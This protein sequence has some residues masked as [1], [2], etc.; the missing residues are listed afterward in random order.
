[1]TQYWGWVVMAGDGLHFVNPKEGDR[2]SAS[3]L[4]AIA[5]IHLAH[6]LAGIIY[7]IVTLVR[8]YKSQVHK[9][10]TLQIS[11]CN[12]YWHFIGLLWVYLY[13]FLYFAPDF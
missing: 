13:M 2:V 6:I 12:T 9:K 4:I 5:A 8:T 1:V 3:F 7:L 10:N 11:M